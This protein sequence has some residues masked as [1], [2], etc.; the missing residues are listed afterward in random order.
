MTID[1]EVDESRDVA[2][3]DVSLVGIDVEGRDAS[4]DGVIMF[5]GGLGEGRGSTLES[6][7]KCGAF[8]GSLGAY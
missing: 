8:S 1:V 6:T 4:G 3:A 7:K 2:K 5:D